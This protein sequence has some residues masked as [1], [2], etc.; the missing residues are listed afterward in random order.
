[1]KITID[2]PDDIGVITLV[3][4]QQYNDVCQNVT[5]ASYNKSDLKNKTIVLT[6]DWK[7]TY[8]KAKRSR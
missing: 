5:T 4:L 1:M 3:M 2:V 7:T 6:D 8:L